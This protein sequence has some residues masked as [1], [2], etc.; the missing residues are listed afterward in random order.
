M[1]EA[2]GRPPYLASEPKK[3]KVK[4]FWI[5]LAGGAIYA[6]FHFWTRSAEVVPAPGT[7]PVTQAPIE[8]EP[9]R[10]RVIHY[11]VTDGDIPADIFEAHGGLDA[12]D[13]AA[14]I[15]AGESVYDMAKIRIGRELRFYFDGEDKAKRI[16]Y[17]RD[18]ER[19]I[20]A[21][22]SGQDFDV[23]EEKINYDAQEDTARGE[24]NNFFYV[25]AMGSGL[26]EATV[27]ETGDLFSF[28]IDFTTELRLGD[29]FSIVYEKRTRDGQPA[30][31]GRILAARFTN[32][33]MAHYIYY[34]DNNG[35][36]GYYDA[37]GRVIERQFLKAPLSYRRISSGFTG[38]RYH[39][40]TRKVSAHYQID[41][42]AP[43]GTHVVS[44]ARGTV[45]SAGWEG[46]WGN[47]VRLR[48]DNGYTTHY[49]HL[50]G[51]AKG[52]RSG[53][54]VAQGQLIGYVG[55]TGW[56][57][58]PHLDYGMKLDGAPVNPLKLDLP[59]GTPLAP[60]RKAAFEEI[61]GKYAQKLD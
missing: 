19:I 21:E 40:V 6:G 53:A 1:I 36:G 58:G 28:S 34:F 13:V 11:T 26:S 44:T 35:Q 56:S 10:E 55:S 48:H 8:P 33:G 37:E 46:G 14:L 39:P 27:L 17:E 32:D 24:I 61:R 42:A 9:A 41:Y 38:A 54:S 43:T 16:E 15:T 5:L 22:R 45:V 18:S 7:P 59:K 4:Y 57:T 51:I 29:T 47:M 12:N 25:D 52:I 50:S 3:S 30:P 60:D 20:I 2:L 23:R 31:D 49:G